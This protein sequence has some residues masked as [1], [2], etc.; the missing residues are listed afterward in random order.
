[1]LLGVVGQRGNGVTAAFN[2]SPASSMGK[3]DTIW[4]GTP[5]AQPASAHAASPHNGRTG[6]RKTAQVRWRVLVTFYSGGSY[7]RWVP[8]LPV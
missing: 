3:W 7:R 4:S 6:G 5:V 1:M 8:R 2:P